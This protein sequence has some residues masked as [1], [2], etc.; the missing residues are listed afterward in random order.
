[1]QH[2]VMIYN[3]LIHLKLVTSHGLTTVVFTI[4]KY[5]SNNNAV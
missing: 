3:V 2:F 1:M 5:N 4:S